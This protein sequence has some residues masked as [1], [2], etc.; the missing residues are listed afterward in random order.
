MTRN[1]NWTDEDIS[2]LISLH[3]KEKGKEEMSQ[4]LHKPNNSVK[5]KVKQLIGQGIISLK[6]KRC[7]I[8]KSKMLPTERF[9]KCMICFKNDKN[10]FH[11]KL[12]IDIF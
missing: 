10:E 4:I 2:H 5:Y 8:C 11:G 7:Y 6:F 1:I 9:S 3:N 12:L